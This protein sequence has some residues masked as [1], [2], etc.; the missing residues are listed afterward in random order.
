MQKLAEY[1]VQCGS[2]KLLTCKGHDIFLKGVGRL[3]SGMKYLRHVILVCRAEAGFEGCTWRIAPQQFCSCQT[4]GRQNKQIDFS[5]GA[6]QPAF[7]EILNASFK[8][9]N[10]NDPYILRLGECIG[11]RFN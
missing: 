11:A 3:V 10:P 6:R 8:G 4:V 9:A 2:S 1:V 7:A 5:G